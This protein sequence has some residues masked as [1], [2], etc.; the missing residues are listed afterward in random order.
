MADPLDGGYGLCLP[1]KGEE[2]SYGIFLTRQQL[3]TNPLDWVLTEMQKQLQQFLRITNNA[4]PDFDIQAQQ[5]L[6]QTE[7]VWRELNEAN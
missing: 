1:V 6:A 3:T 5:V 2:Q 7:R 4:I